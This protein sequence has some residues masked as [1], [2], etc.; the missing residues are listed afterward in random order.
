MPSA[1]RWPTS[2]PKDIMA[3]IAALTPTFR[4]VSYERLDELGSIQWPCNDDAPDGTPTMHIDHFV[5]G[6]G[7]LH[8]HAVRGD[9]REGHA[10]VP[11]A[12]DDGPHPLAIQRRRADAAHATTI[13][14]HSEDRLE[15][16]PHD[17]EERGIRQD[18]WVGIRSRAGET[19]LRATVSERMQPGVVYTTFHF[20]RV[21]RQRDHHRQFRLG[22][23][24]PRVQG[25]R[26]AGDACDAAFG[27]AAG[28]Q[29]LRPK[30]SRAC[31]RV[32]RWRWQRR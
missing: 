31:S 29:P 24:L 23:Q 16:H 15:I 5:R 8:H 30:S 19:V 3:E 20:P 11:A 2:S 18:D 12:V 28:V 4:G 9:G 26:G 21:G 32:V 27:V 13:E 10:H 17:A 25:D 14:W 7:K 22:H 6:K 1:I